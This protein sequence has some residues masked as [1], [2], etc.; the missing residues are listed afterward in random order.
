LL[1]LA[2]AEESRQQMSF[3]ASAVAWHHSKAK[4]TDLLV[5]M[6]I[7]NYISDQGAWPKMETI[8]HDARTSVRQAHR[9]IVSL[10]E[11]GEIEW[12]KKAGVG[13]G[14]YKSNRYQFLLTC[15]PDCTGDWNHT[16]R[17]NVTSIP[18]NSSGLNMT[19]T[20]DKPVTEPVKEIVIAQQTKKPQLLNESWLPD[21]RLIGMFV[22][23][24]PLLNMSEQTEAFKLHHMAKGSK[25]ADWGLAYQKW[26]NQAQKWAAEKQPA[27]PSRKIVGDF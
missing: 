25:M 13:R 14:I 6:A 10:R 9:S 23:K 20:A 22:T 16:L 11:L 5:L 15:P 1:I 27:T 21:D 19:H 24:W 26:M 17:Q 7:A 4:G 8:A 12:Q 18:A 3:G 2:V